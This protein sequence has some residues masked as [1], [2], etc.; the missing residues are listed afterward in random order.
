MND[1]VYPRE[2]SL[3]L[4]TLILGILVWL[5]LI[6]GTFGAALLVLAFGFILYLFAQSGFIAHIKGNGVELS[7]AQYPDLHAQFTA[8]CEKLQLT[9]TPRA[10]ILNG[11]GGLNAFATR[12]LGKEFIVLLSD[13]VDAMAQHPDGVRFYIGHELGHLR[14]KHLTGHL[15][16]WPV[17]WLPLLGAAYA[18][19]Q[20]STCDRHGLACCA[21]PEGAARSL[22]ALSAG[23][24]RWQGMNL[25]DFRRQT[26]ETSGFWM[27]FHE[28]V[29]GYA[30]VTKRVARVLDPAAAM[31]RRN[32]FAY[33]FALFVPYAGRLGAGFGFLILV[34]ILF[35]IA[36]IALPAYLDYSAR[37]ELAAVVDATSALR[38]TIGDYYEAQETIPESLEALGLPATLPDGSGLTLSTDDMTLTVATPHGDLVFTPTLDDDGQVSWSCSDGW[39]MK[40]TH[41]PPQCQDGSA[42]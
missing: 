24:E 3:G 29:S 12:F 35:V 31:P 11:N 9:K 6:V 42:E 25:D 18:R 32:P 38:G 2:R 14:M 19:A 1:L 22:A 26:A 34:Y 4:I 17:L 37:A 41:L 13:T 27:S 5:L 8:C 15:L 20:E 30:W 23:V 10:F 16:R 33:L 36:A 21:T 28:L 40:A 7:A 39:N